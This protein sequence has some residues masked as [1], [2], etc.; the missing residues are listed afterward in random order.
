MRSQRWPG[1]GRLGAALLIAGLAFFLGGSFEWVPGLWIASAVAGVTAISSLIYA[2]SRMHSAVIL[3]VDVAWV[4]LATLA[5]GRPDAGITLFFPLV[6]FASGL[7]VG[8]RG[9]WAISVVAGSALVATSLV[10][11]GQAP[12]QLL[13][14]GAMVFVLG[15][16]SGRVRSSVQLQE[17][18]LVHASKALARM[19]LDTDSIVEHLG[20]GL[21]SVDSSGRIVHVNRVAVQTLGCDPDELRGRTLREGLPS[22]ANALIEAIELA[23]SHG[24]SEKRQEIAI[25]KN[26]E[27]VPIGVG[28]T[29]LRDQDGATAGVAVLF[30]DLT[31]ILRE[32][33][34]QHRRQRMAAVGELAAGIAHEIRNSILPVSGSVQL[35]TQ[36]M[37]PNEEQAKLF[38]VIERETENIEG[39]VSSLLT[40]TR[41]S[42]IKPRV[43]DLTALVH[44]MTRELS[45]AGRDKRDIEMMGEECWISADQEQLRQVV[46][47]LLVNAADASG[48]DGKVRVTVGTE[49][50]QPWF[51]IEDNG[52]GITTE[53]EGQVFQPFFTTKHGGTGLG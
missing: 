28:M 42:Q 50:D 49:D 40:Y 46:R 11:G 44:D 19:R 14:Q 13:L 24:T 20:S 45:L 30:Q 38:E 52:P 36:E 12:T 25:T 41:V 43:F 2:S 5:A 9:A 10:L 48:T 31:E 18:A 6:A 7:T 53:N 47:N 35:L 34:L 51:Q 17:R 39:F 16:V 3:L 26:G 32:E 23:M 1:F 29:V 22:G 15:G 4:S 33:A 37:N 8:G 27:S 21:I